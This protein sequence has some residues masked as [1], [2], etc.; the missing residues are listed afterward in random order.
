MALLVESTDH[1]EYQ[2]W[3]NQVQIG[4]SACEDMTQLS[5]VGP[6]TKAFLERLFLAVT[7][8][9]S[10]IPQFP[11]PTNSQPDMDTIMGL[12]EDDWDYFSEND[13]FAQF[14]CGGL[15]YLDDQFLPQHYQPFA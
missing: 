9:S 10:T 14:D 1:C 13:A 7:N 15:S 5:P 8:A 6:K 12:L 4:I 3:C 2:S 11:A